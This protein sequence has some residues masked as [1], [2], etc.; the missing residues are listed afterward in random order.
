VKLARRAFPLLFLIGISAADDQP[1]PQLSTMEYVL[2]P[3]DTVPTKDDIVKL[4]GSTTAI[5]NLEAL[6]AGDGD[7]GVQLRAIGALPRFCTGNCSSGDPHD[8][9]VNVITGID[10]SDRRGT[11]LLR[12]RAGIE[13]LGSTR[14]GL[15]SDVNRLVPFLDDASRDIRVATARALRDLCNTQAIVPL[16]VRYEME[17]VAQVRLAISAALRDLGQCS[18]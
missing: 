10:T 11:T 1:A 6:I 12:L 3:I 2:T 15:T 5:D 16:R 8:S 14:S 17:L 4:F 13:A 18:P 7:F 9:I